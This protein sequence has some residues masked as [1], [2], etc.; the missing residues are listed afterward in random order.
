MFVWRLNWRQSLVI[1]GFITLVW[2]WGGRSFLPETK[3]LWAGWWVQQQSLPLTTG[4][5]IR[6]TVK[7]PHWYLRFQAIIRAWRRGLSGELALRGV[8]YLLAF[9]A[10]GWIW[11]LRWAISQMVKGE[12][13]PEVA[14]NWGWAGN[15]AHHPA[16]IQVRL[17]V[18]VSAAGE[19]VGT[20]R[21]LP[22][23]ARGEGSE[24]ELEGSRDK[25]G[26]DWPL[27]ALEPAEGALGYG[28]GSPQTGV[29]QPLQGESS[30]SVRRVAEP[31]QESS[32]K[33][34]VPAPVGSLM[35]HF[36][37]LADPRIERTKKHQ[38]FDIVVITICAVIGGADTWV[39]VADFG[40]DQAQWFKTFLCLP[41]GLPS[42]DTFGRVFRD[43]DPQQWQA[44]FLSWIQA[45]NQMTQGQIVPIDGKMLRRSHDKTL[46]KKAIHMVSA[47]A[48]ENR[49]VLG[50]VKVDEKSNEITAIPVLLDMLAISGCIVTIDAMGCQKE[51]ARKII[52]KGAQYVLALKG[53][54][55]GLHEEVKALFAKFQLTDF[56][57]GHYH[58]TE[59][60]GHGRYESRQCWTISDPKSLADLQNLAAWKGLQSV[61][62][63]RAERHSNTK[64][65]VEDRYFISSLPG[66]AQPLL[67]AVRG[68]WSIENS[69]H[70]VLDIAFA[71][72]ECRIRKGHGAQNFAVLRHIALNLLKQETTVKSGIKAKRKMAG[73]NEDYL[74]KVLAGFT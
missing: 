1:V 66:E 2:L 57:P 67:Q 6:R 4:R 52:A 59:E 71:E 28:P 65:S 70:W 54:Q 10:V 17:Q 72:D 61:V 46:G 16:T 20:D 41:H 48:A 15:L 7:W 21:P 62:R 60:N 34:E 3:L 38:L 14:G 51:I 18:V 47:W 27:K 45:V 74:L 69:L 49:V 36:S 30:I 25:P 5:T 40:R 50:Q 55:S 8:C 58:H 9:G 19:P 22:G 39:E 26:L 13:E 73:R 24:I 56:A 53:N 31:G 32:P 11:L 42:H 35:Q 29:S 44:G 37:K 64:V 63:V 68:H 12:S 43:L 33:P 23:P